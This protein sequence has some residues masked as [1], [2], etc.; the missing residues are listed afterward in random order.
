MIHNT[1]TAVIPTLLLQIVVV[2]ADMEVIVGTAADLEEAEEVAASGVETVEDT[3]AA[4]VEDTK[5]VEG[6]ETSSALQ[7]ELS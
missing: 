4:A 2:E 3:A 6:N 7:S 1:L 5:W